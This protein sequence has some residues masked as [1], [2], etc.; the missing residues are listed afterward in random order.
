MEMM[1][2][3]HSLAALGHASRLAIFRQLVQAGRG[4][5]MAGELAQALSLPGATLSFHLKELAAA[6]LIQGEARGRYVN[7]RADFAAMNDLIEFLT[8]NCCGG[9]TEVCAPGA[10]S[11]A[12]T[13]ADAT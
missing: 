4:G 10:R 2:A 11:C 6:G 8:R 5:R 9:D 1:E 12:P 13:P 3:T 7:Y